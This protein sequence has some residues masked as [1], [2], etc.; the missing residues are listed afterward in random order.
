MWSAASC[1]CQPTGDSLLKVL[2]IPSVANTSVSSGSSASI[3][4]R[5]GGS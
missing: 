4:A 5:S 1:G 3:A 2:A